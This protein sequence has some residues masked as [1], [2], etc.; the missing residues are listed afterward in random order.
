MKS[1][2]PVK[3]DRPLALFRIEST[4]ISPRSD[5]IIELAVIRIELDGSETT[6]DWLVNPAIPIPVENT[7]VHGINRPCPLILP[8]TIPPPGS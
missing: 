4:G 2:F 1:P 3:L 8:C 7:T 5:R 6:I